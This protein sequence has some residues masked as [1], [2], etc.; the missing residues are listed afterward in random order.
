MLGHILSNLGQSCILSGNIGSPPISSVSDLNK[1]R[2]KWN[3]CEVSSYQARDLK[4]F[5]P[6]HVLWTNFS[7]N[8]LDVHR[9]FGEYW[10]AKWNLLLRSGGS[11]YVGQNVALWAEKFSFRLPN[12]VRIVADKWEGD[13]EF[14]AALKISHQRANYE[15]IRALLMDLGF[16][17]QAI[18]EAVRGF[19]PPPHRLHLHGTFEN[20]DL[21]SDSKATTAAAAYSALCHVTAE[22]RPCLW[23][24]CGRKKGGSFE[25]YRSSV[26]AASEIVCFGEIAEEM[27]KFF[28]GNKWRILQEKEELFECMG[29][30][31]SRQGGQRA[32]VLFSPGFASFDQFS[33]YAARGEWFERG[34]D[35]WISAHGGTEKAGNGAAP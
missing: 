15:L 28:G 21:W 33:G 7:E 4:F 2:D 22:R 1:H 34:M 31:I 20:V 25:C 19:C 27:V 35:D 24:T 26:E 12:A 30:F 5:A 18:V 6:R 32:A 29:E 11:P 9:T 14:C 17:S 8:H 13:G 10:E 23:I 3:I 16:S